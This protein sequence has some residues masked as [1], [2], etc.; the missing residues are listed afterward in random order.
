MN[1]T[2]QLDFCAAEERARDMTERELGA[3]LADILMTLPQADAWDRELG[4]DRGGRYR[5]EASV[6]HAELA[7]RAGRAS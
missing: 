1:T 2:H 4:G 7:R 3:A 6:Y 5:D